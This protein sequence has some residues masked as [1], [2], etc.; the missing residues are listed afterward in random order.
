MTR[1]KFMKWT[2]FFFVFAVFVLVSACSSEYERMVSKEL[3][4]GVRQDSILLGINFGDTS[5][6]FFERCWKLNKEGIISHGPKNMNVQYTIKHPDSAASN[7]LVLFYPDFD[8]DLKINK[9]DI[10]FNYAGWAPWNEQ[11]QSDKLLPVVLDTLQSW[12]G[13]NSF[14]Q[15]E[16]DEEPKNVWVKVDGNRRVSVSATK[17]N[18]VLV[19]IKDLLSDEK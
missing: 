2:R 16:F 5:K 7:I 12:Y 13:G 6:D 8:A 1:Y 15:V 18:M 19:K 9:M 14:I 4:S 17:S 3:E 11:Y 10:E